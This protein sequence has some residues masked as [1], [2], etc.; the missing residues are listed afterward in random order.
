M[1]AY[2]N[3]PPGA[4]H[5]PSPYKISVSE[6]KISELKA[7]LKVAKVA[8]PTF[9]NMQ[10]DPFDNK[11]GLN[12]RWLIDAKSRWETQFLWYVHACYSQ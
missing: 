2:A 9:E 6:D 5:A 7:L 8:A 10:K 4:I 11:F 1:A 12:A 3:I